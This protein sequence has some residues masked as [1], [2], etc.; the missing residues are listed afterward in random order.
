VLRELLH[1][2]HWLQEA[3]Q[4]RHTVLAELLDL[5]PTSPDSSYGLHLSGGRFLTRIGDIS[6]KKA[7]LNT[8]AVI[9][10]GWERRA[11]DDDLGKQ[12]WRRGSDDDRRILGQMVA[13]GY[14][15]SAVE[16]LVLVDRETPDD[17]DATPAAGEEDDPDAA[18]DADRPEVGDEA[19]EQF[20]GGDFV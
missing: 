15:P 3:M 19:G 8:A 6:A 9:F 16:E 5:K 17:S 4:R 12:T 13:W 18:G 14:P 7:T 10:A 1:G 2:P 11:G 20:V